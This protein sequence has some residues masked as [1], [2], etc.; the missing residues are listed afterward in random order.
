M[1]E[2][3]C[4]GIT[5]GWDNLLAVI[6]AD[7]RFPLVPAGNDHDAP[8]DFDGLKDVSAPGLAPLP[9]IVMDKSTDIVRANLAAQLFPSSMDRCGQCT[10]CREALAGCGGDGK[11]CAMATRKLPISTRFNEV[12]KQVG[13]LLICALGDA[14]GLADPGS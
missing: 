10:P 14:A 3:H 11:K 9:V 13:A 8:M 4:G 6:R 2:K 5:G 7:H 12:T 1:I